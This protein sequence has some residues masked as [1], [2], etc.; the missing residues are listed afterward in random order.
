MDKRNRLKINTPETSFNL[1]TDNSIIVQPRIT[2]DY[3]DR[4]IEYS[5]EQKKVFKPSSKIYEILR[6]NLILI[7]LSILVL[8]LAFK[9]SDYS[10]LLEEIY[11]LRQ[12]N[13]S[14]KSKKVFENICL[15]SNGVTVTPL[16][17]VYKYGFLK[18][19]FSDPLAML[20]S[21]SECFSMEGNKGKFQITFKDKKHIQ[22]I[23]IYHPSNANNKSCVKEFSVL[24]NGVNYHFNFNGIGFQEFF[25]SDSDDKITVEILSNYGEPKY[26]SIYRFYVFGE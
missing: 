21:S 26:T 11:I 20:D 24:V 2:P 8:Y 25:I 17:P 3:F 5:A 1:T 13:K 12:E 23:G 18:R 15:I 9:P 6:N 7:G 19:S 22:K 4:D 14:I 16:S 10:E